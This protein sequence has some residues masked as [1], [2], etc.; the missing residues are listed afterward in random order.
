MC[1]INLDIYQNA[2]FSTSQM[3]SLEGFLQVNPSI[4]WISL[5]SETG[6]YEL[7]LDNQM[8]SDFRACPAYFFESHVRGLGLRGTAQRNW[9]LDIGTLFHYMIESYYGKFRALSFELQDW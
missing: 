5:N 3:H 9:H 7:V 2:G 1:A 6:I 4:H 8:M